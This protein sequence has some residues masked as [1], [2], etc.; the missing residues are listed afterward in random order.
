MIAEPKVSDHHF[1][2]HCFTLLGIA[3][4]IA[5]DALWGVEEGL[6]GE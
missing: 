2:S 4:P 3:S 1:T 6:A 5:G